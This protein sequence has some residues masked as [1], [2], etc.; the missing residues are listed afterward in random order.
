VQ[1]G[2]GRPSAVQ[3]SSAIG[4]EAADS[5]PPAAVPRGHHRARRYVITIK[6]AKDSVLVF[7]DCQV[8]EARRLSPRPETANLERPTANV[9]LTRVQTQ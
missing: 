3:R 9:P 1:K 5:T 4:E 6:T 8:R 2:G 7:R